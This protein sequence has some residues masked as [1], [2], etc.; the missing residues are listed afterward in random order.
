M[1]IAQDRE[2]A[3]LKAQADA[4]KTYGQILKDVRESDTRTKGV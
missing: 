4:D 1:K 3:L 2:E